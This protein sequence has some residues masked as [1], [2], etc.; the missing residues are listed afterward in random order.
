MVERVLTL[1]QMNFHRRERLPGHG[2]RREVMGKIRP[3]SKTSRDS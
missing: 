1:A 2:R 3:V